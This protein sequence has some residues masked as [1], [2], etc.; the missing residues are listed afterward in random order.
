L[1][2]SNYN[3]H[4][5][6]FAR[7][8]RKQG[9]KGEAMLWKFILKSKK[10]GYTFNRQF[11]IDNYIVDFICRKLKLII[12][13]DGGSHLTKENNNDFERQ[14]KIESLGYKFLRFTESDIVKE[15]EAIIRSIEFAI[16]TI[17]ENQK[18]KP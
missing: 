5:K 3:K 6:H 8:H 15:L 12:E 2:K 10:T 17:E 9:T 13:I 4:L 7:K 14:K 11:P 16:Y 18:V 1:E